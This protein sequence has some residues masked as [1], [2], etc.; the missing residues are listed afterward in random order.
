MSRDADD[1]ADLVGTEDGD[2]DA[3]GDGLEGVLQGQRDRKAG[4]ADD[5]EER[6][7]VEAE[8]L[9]RGDE[10]DGEGAEADKGAEKGEQR[11]AACIGAAEL[12]AELA[13][14]RAEP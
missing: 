2:D 14:A 9:Q 6:G 3:G 5:G 7:G 4:G 8:L 13:D 12:L 11:L 10:A 1:V